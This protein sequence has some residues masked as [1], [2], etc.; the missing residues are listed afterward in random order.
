M[1]E[2]LHLEKEMLYPCLGRMNT[3]I[4]THDKV[5]LIYLRTTAQ[6]VSWNKLSNWTRT[7]Y[8]Y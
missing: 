8:W 5:S 3:I 6:T 7:V 4:M 1:H 2:L